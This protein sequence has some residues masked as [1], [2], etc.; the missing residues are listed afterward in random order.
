[1]TAAT[2]GKIQLAEF[3]MPSLGADMEAG[4]VVE[5]R[6]KPG[7]AVRRG[8]VVGVVETDKGAVEMEIFETGVIDQLVVPVGEQVPVGSVLAL[9]RNG[10]GVSVV[11]PSPVRPATSVHQRVSPLARTS[12]ASRA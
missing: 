11:K 1:M 5:W 7:D 12:L 4:T 9:L 6:V 2:D 8:Q 3:R 10:S